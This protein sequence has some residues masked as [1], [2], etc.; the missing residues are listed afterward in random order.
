MKPVC[1][2]NGW[3][4]LPD[5]VVKADIYVREGK[6]SRISLVGEGA[7]S[8]D[9]EGRILNAEHSNHDGDREVF[10]AGNSIIDARRT[11]INVEHSNMDAE[12]GSSSIEHSV[13]HSAHAIMPEEFTVIDASGSYVLPGLI[14]IHNDAIE[15]E[16]QP[17]PNTLF[18]LEMS[19]LEFERKLPLHGITTMYHSLSLGVGLSLRGD[20]LLTEMVELINQYRTKRSIIR[21]RIHLRYEISHLKGM[22][23]VAQ[24]IEENKIDYLSFMDHSP[25]QGQYRKEGS[26]ERYVMKNQ[27]MELKEAQALVVDLM[28]RRQRIDWEQLRQLGRQ[29]I[30]QGISLASHDDDSP[31][32]VDVFKSYGINVTEFPI[33]LETAQYATG[34]DMA[35]C[36]GAPNI[37][38]GVSHDQNLRAIDAIA[39]G[40][41][42]IICSDYHS[43]SLLQS[44][45]KLADEGIAALPTAVRMAT[46]HPA[47]ACGI[48]DEAGSIEPGKAADLIIVQRY[49]GHP[50]VTHTLVDG[51]TVYAADIR[52]QKD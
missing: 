10:R 39:S 31:E 13:N 37:V 22:H 23:I 6:I 19:L 52:Y 42:S 36:V 2:K 41:A 11:A 8:A 32:R 46:L 47:Q 45:F 33:N 43:S 25:G 35:V 14:D 21:N 3:V 1:I 9:A 27:G 34:E 28:E 20:H 29:A 51:K 24:Y 50:W 16:V 26:F 17:R 49:K 7:D 40:A 30:Q 15:K 12:K 4:V 18:P 5:A 44:I 38:R 48:A